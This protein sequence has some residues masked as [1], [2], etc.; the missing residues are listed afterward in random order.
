MVVWRLFRVSA[1]SVF[2]VAS[3]QFDDNKNIFYFDQVAG[4]TVPRYAISY[5]CQGRG[6]TLV[7]FHTKNAARRSASGIAC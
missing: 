3:D 2:S 4:R 5:D 6:H 1:F 7:S